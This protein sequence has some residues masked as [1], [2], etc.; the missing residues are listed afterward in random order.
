MYKII[1]GLL[2]LV[3]ICLC[4]FSCKTQQTYTTDSFEGKMLTFGTSGGF[5]GTI[6]ENYFFENGQFMH[7]TS[8]PKNTITHKNIDQEIVDQAFS[9]FYSLGFDDLEVNDPGNLNYYIKLKEGEKEKVLLWGGNND[10]VP[11]ILMVYFKN[12][13]QIAQKFQN[14]EK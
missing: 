7:H 6:S 1:A 10:A 13:S 5:A 11:E 3:L 9:N 14:V 8:R 12:L 4:S 2:S